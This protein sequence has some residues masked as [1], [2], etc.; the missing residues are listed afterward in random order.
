[1]DQRAYLAIATLLNSFPQGTA[2]PDLTMGT[3]EAV[4]Q[5]LSPQAVTEAAQR[6]TMGDV[7]GQSKTFAPS[8]AEFVAE[9]RQRQE[10]I[11][12]KARP[13]LPAPRY[14]PGPLAPFQVRQEK[15]RA[16][17][18]GRPVIEANAP[19]DRFIAMSRAKQLP[20]DAIWVAC[21]GILGPAPK[22]KPVAAE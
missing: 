12:I 7:P 20:T 21:M 4:L 14:F 10:Y 1:M 11:D 8:I 2:D 19:L 22:Q 13:R 5:D 9:A 6:F 17:Y 3:Y 15:R 16:E 18:A